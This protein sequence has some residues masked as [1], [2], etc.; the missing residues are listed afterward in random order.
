MAK[1]EV[2]MNLRNLGLAAGLASVMGVVAWDAQAHCD[3]IDGPVAKAAVKALETGN[4][5]LALP[6]APAEA[7]KEIQ[8][9]FAQARK[10]RLLNADARVLADRS[11]METVVR[12]HRAGE[13]AP[14][15][16]LK[17]AGDH[18]AVIPAAER[19]IATGDPA[20]LRRLLAGDVEHALEER[21]AEARSLR[22]V[23]VE[24][25]THTDVAR[26]RERISAELEFVA[27]AESVRQAIAG[28]LPGHHEE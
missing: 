11:F 7:E 10:V 1:M 2:A 6:Y 13:G 25:S 4:V 14:F 12:L 26:A 17:P 23:S 28:N 15:T 22:R 24:P 3:A 27:F 8:T 21:L 19:A 5:F 16:G 9:A 20:A 18:G